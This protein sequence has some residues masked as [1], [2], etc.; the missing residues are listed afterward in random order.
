MTVPTSTGSK[1]LDHGR[2]PAEW[3]E[4]LCERGVNITER[5]LREKANK[6]STCGKLGKEMLI[7]PEH[8][9]EMFMEDQSC[10]S[11]SIPE[12]AN[13]G[14]KVGLNTKD[15]QSPVTTE[16]LL[17][18]LQSKVQSNGSKTKR[19]GKGVVTSWVKKRSN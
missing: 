15:C 12:K 7:L 10:H 18:H 4:I 3:A 1:F 11:K 17:D 13:G 6:L 9:D 19:I 8:L 14:S 5:T 16:N 2:T